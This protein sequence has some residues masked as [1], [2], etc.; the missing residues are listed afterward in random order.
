M[1]LRRGSLVLLIS[2]LALVTPGSARPA[3]T[4]TTIVRAPIS[5][6]L[7]TNCSVPET[8]A[9][10]GMSQSVFHFVLDGQGTAHFSGMSQSNGVG[11]GLLTGASYRFAGAS[12]SST[13]EA[14]DT[15]PYHN[16]FT[17]TFLLVSRGS[18]DN[19][20]MHVTQHVT[21][22]PEGVL[23][24]EVLNTRLECVG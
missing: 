15:L 10:S 9:F 18:Q 5:G 20:Q 16:T 22:T 1:H 6:F 23:T 13:V 24:A 2:L 17:D 8:I 14:P 7:V 3:T 19:L 12:S 11:T 4:I 21:V